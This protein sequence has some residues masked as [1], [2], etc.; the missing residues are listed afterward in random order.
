[1]GIAITLQQYL[2]DHA[3]PYE[4]VQHKRTSSAM[5]SAEASHIQSD[6]LAK[7][8]VLRRRDGFILAV[9]PASR[10]VALDN[11]GGWLKQPVGLATEEEVAG[12]F[13]DCEPGAV[14]PVAAAYGLKSLVDESLEAM[15]EVFFEAGDHRTLVHVSREQFHKLMEKVP[16][17]RFSTAAVSG[18]EKKTSSSTGGDYPDWEYDI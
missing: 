11:V 18:A 2:S 6:C 12:L 3:I 10:Q 4:C 7:A 13:P 14:P 5:R 15:P 1:M 17:G 16:H 9:L 8:V